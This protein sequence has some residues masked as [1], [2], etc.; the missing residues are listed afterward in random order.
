MFSHGG[1]TNLPTLYLLVRRL[2][3]A[4]IGLDNKR[5]FDHENSRTAHLAHKEAAR[6]S[7]EFS[8]TVDNQ[9]SHLPFST[10]R[11]HQ[12][13]RNDSDACLRG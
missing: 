7:W 10:R 8:K 3:Q 12:H 9:H 4:L 13:A 11:N 5:G 6:G 1:T 2:R